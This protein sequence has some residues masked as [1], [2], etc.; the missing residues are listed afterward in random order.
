MNKQCHFC[1][2]KSKVVDYKDVEILKSFLDTHGRI[3]KHRRTGTCA[4]HQRQVATA[5]KQARFLALLPFIEG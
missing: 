5:I 1:T 3:N 4:K 2:G